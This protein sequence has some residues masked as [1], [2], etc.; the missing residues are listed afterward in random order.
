MIP[1]TDS[2][3]R[4]FH[5]HFRMVPADT[6]LLRNEA[7]RI[8]YAVYCDELGFEDPQDHPDR[9]E[10]DPF[11]AH[12]LHALLQH[13]PSG[14]FVGCVRLILASA[15][16]P[17]AQFPFERFCHRALQQDLSSHGRLGRAVI[18]EISR[19][20]VRSDFRRRSG[21]RQHP[22]G[23]MESLDRR[24]RQGRVPEAHRRLF[25]FI[26]PTLY[27]TGAAMALERGLSQA[28]VMMEPRLAR[29][30]RRYGIM[31]EQVGNVVDYHGQ[32]GPFRIRREDLLEHLKP[33]MRAL[34]EAIRSEIHPARTGT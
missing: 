27:L 7:Y 23:L 18:G 3:I 33:R 1:G 9:L 17:H 34:L 2:L 31:F 14:E 4:Q 6:P 15:D 22:V 21:E 32:R 26:A 28:Y 8:R 10:R 20:A 11:D 16:D 30:L 12:A 19:L 29:H 5:R 25:P 13:Q 24:D